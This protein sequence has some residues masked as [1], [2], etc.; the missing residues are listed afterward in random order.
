M[1]FRPIAPRQLTREEV[2]AISCENAKKFME[3]HPDYHGSDFNG[4][5]LAAFIESQVGTQYP[6]TLENYEAAYGYLTETGLLETSPEDRARQAHYARIVDQSAAAKKQR[7]EQEIVAKTERLVASTAALERQ[8]RALP[9]A[10][11]KLIVARERPAYSKK[12]VPRVAPVQGEESR[13]L[14]DGLSLRQHAAAMVERDYPGISRR[15][16]EYE[17]RVNQK[18][19]ELQQGE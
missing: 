16:S 10:D 12:P 8:I 4:E 18:I 6:W 17:R 19:H 5:A 2:N 13:R 3:I 15:K 1:A 14:D 9:D 7:E 11:L